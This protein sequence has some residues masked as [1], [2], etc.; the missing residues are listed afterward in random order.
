[1]PPLVA[2]GSLFVARWFV[3][4]I[5]Q[6]W[7]SHKHTPCGRAP[8]A[9]SALDTLFLVFLIYAEPGGR[10]EPQDAARRLPGQGGPVSR[11]PATRWSG[12]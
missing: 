10:V 5:S 4:C 3:T 7:P 12:D 8:G 2:R 11:L 9:T 1:M 6:A